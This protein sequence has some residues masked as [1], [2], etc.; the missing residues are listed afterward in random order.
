MRCNL[1]NSL[2]IFTI[3]FLLSLGLVAFASPIMTVSATTTEYY[4]VVNE[5]VY[6]FNEDNKALF[7]I[8]KTYYLLKNGQPLTGDYY[9]AI[10]NGVDG[11]ILKTSVTDAT[12]LSIDEPYFTQ[13]LSI[14]S[15][16]TFILVHPTPSA[17]AEELIY[18]NNTTTTFEFLG[19]MN[20]SDTT[21]TDK[22]YYVRYNTNKY[23]YIIPS[24]TNNTE[25]LTTIAP[26]AN[27]LVNPSPSPSVSPSPNPNA[28]VEPTN[29]LL[30]VLLILGISVPAVIVV[31]LLF[32]PSHSKGANRRPRDRDYYDDYYDD[33]D[34][35]YYYD[36]YRDN[37]REYRDPRRRR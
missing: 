20:D 12:V 13:T 15:G 30:R 19:L 6:F 3:I 4:T 7:I 31:F 24:D 18:I 2:K 10:Y 16:K 11:K 8:P 29:N 26:H 33:Y 5:E 36:D 22:W 21:K 14:A 27:S 25:L 35:D 32:R 9:R 37:R 28:P 23:G 17:L 1:R 34:D